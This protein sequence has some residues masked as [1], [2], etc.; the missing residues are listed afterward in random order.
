MA[1][2]MLVAVMKRSGK[3][4]DTLVFAVML[5]TVVLSSVMSN[6]AACIIFLSASLEFL[7]IYDNEADKRR[8]GRTFMIALPIAAQTG[9]MYTPASSSLNMMVLTQ[10]ES[11][12]GLE[13]QFIKWMA[14]GIPMAI[15][16]TNWISR[17]AKDSS[18]V[19]TIIFNEELAGVYMLPV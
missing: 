17:P 9:S 10:L 4:V 3:S 11:L 16:L 8:T 13:I 15:H 7:K 12:A 1:K 18:W 19:K 2:R 6:V 5:C 14:M